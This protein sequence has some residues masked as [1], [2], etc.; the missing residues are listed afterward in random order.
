M[1]MRRSFKILVLLFVLIASAGGL[2]SCIPV[3]GDEMAVAEAGPRAWIDFP[4][5]GASAPV[6]A[7]VVVISHAYAEDGVVEVLLSV[8]GVAYRRDP[9]TSVGDALVEARQEWTPTEPGLY[10]LEV[11]AYNAAGEIGGSDAITV[12][13]TGDA[14]PT[15][16][17]SPTEVPAATL[18]P[19]E[20][21]GATA[22]PVPT[23]TPV[24]TLVPTDVPV[25][26]V[27]FTPVPPPQVSFWV[28]DDSIT[29]GEC[30]TLHWEVSWTTYLEVN[31]TEV[32]GTGTWSVCPES[33]VTYTIHAEGPGGTVDQSLVVTVSAPPDTT[34]PPVPTPQVP[35]DGL[36]VACSATGKQTLAW[37][38]VDDPSGVVYYVKLERKVT[39]TSWESVRGWGPVEG[40]QVEADVDCGVIY[41]WAVRAQD[42]AGN[43]SAWSVWFNFSVDLT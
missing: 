41:R 34:P 20:V 38:P 11:R 43:F 37:L 31:G 25:P 2:I 24:P 15:E 16:V 21:P 3:P 10:T 6:G 32:A 18:V 42:G 35:A 33:T 30:T 26:T 1:S 23:V 17:G 22:T 4:R 5:D 27:T 9:P 40:K 7:P 29:A 19:T 13:V 39:A 14:L 28:D 8:N 36:V 12:R